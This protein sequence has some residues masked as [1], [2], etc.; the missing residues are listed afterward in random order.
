MATEVPL[1]PAK[2]KTLVLR[3]LGENQ[4][5]AIATLRP[6]GWPQTTIVGFVHDDLTLYFAVSRQSQKLANLEHDPRASIAIGHPHPGDSKIRGLSMA[7][8]VT[9][10]EEAY[11]IERLNR[12]IYERYP[13]VA[14]FAPRESNS[15]VLR[16]TP[17]LVSLVDET[18]GLEQPVLLETS[19]HTELGPVR[20]S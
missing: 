4:T 12:L 19:V 9:K 20:Q 15:A 17:H 11:E 3:V 1:D 2:L 7:A 13:G 10:V 16:A 6:D 18:A 8:R 5:M 14:V